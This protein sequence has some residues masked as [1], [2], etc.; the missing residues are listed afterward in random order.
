MGEETTN[1]MREPKRC[2]Y[3]ESHLHMKYSPCLLQFV[4]NGS[5]SLGTC[6]IYVCVCMHAYPSKYRTM[7][8]I[9]R[10]G[11]KSPTY[12]NFHFPVQ[13]IVEQQVVSHPYSMWFHGMTLPIV[14]IANV[15]WAK[16]K[17]TG[18]FIG[19]TANMNSVTFPLGKHKNH[20]IPNIQN[21][22]CQGNDS[23][24]LLTEQLTSNNFCFVQQQNTVA[25]C[26]VKLWLCCERWVSSLHF[27][28]TIQMLK[29]VIYWYTIYI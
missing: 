6:N 28:H 8:W 7:I 17:A 10:P 14:V 13:T 29:C 19:K 1:K 3:Q 5:I 27:W 4:Q 24:G 16:K 15:T 20:I 9:S 23:F 22:H 25:L 26:S 2:S 11:W 18:N 21:T 12:I